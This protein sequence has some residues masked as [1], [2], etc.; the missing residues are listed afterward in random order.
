MAGSKGYPRNPS[1]EGR[2]VADANRLVLGATCKLHPSTPGFTNLLIRRVGDQF[3][4]DAH[5]VGTC[6]FTLGQKEIRRLLTWL[7]DHLSTD[8][9]VPAMHRGAVPTR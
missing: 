8:Q 2:P 9:Q 4:I 3:V 6:T 7:V 5:A 1:R